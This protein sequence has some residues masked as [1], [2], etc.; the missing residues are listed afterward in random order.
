MRARGGGGENARRGGLGLLARRARADRLSGGARAPGG[1]PSGHLRSPG[2]RLMPGEWGLCCRRRGFQRR[3][4]VPAAG[5]LPWRVG[6]PGG[7]W[8][9]MRAAEVGWV[10]GREG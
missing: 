1:G 10:V 5:R 3:G 9:E 2:R 6:E 7:F 8:S 4:H